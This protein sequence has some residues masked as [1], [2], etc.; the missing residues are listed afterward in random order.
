MRKT[1]W[2][3]L[4]LTAVALTLVAAAASA[5]RYYY[6]N[7]K[8]ALFSLD[9]PA[10]WRVEPEGDVLHAGPRDGS[11]YLG[12]WV[13]KERDVDDAAEAVE[14]IVE[15]MVNGFR[16]T[17]EDTFDRNG[18]RF[19]YLDGQG[20]DDDGNELAVSVALFAPDGK[21]YCILLYFGAAGTSDRHDRALT[22][23]VESIRRE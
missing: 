23:I 17:G 18:I 19:W 7:D 2:L 14:D 12:L 9:I 11:V 5:E 16:S 3:P 21:H 20:R 15:K 6:P 4:A 10:D 8:S 1:P 22:A 13:V